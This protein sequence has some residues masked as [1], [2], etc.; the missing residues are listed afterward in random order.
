MQAGGPAAKTRSIRAGSV[1]VRLAA[2]TRLRSSA[3]R[4]TRVM[5][6]VTAVAIPPISRVRRSS[7]IAAPG[8]G[9]PGHTQH[10]ASGQS[11]MLDVPGAAAVGRPQVHVD[12]AVARRE[13]PAMRVGVESDGLDALVAD[14]EADLGR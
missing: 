11:Q 10:P 2:S 13:D 1:T 5:P 7:L 12:V 4:P 6:A 14:L 9:A 3:P 8:P